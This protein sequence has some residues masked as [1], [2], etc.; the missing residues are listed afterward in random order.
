MYMEFNDFIK[1]VADSI[2]EYLLQYEI[3]KVH[4]DKVSKNNGIVCTGMSIVLKGESI[5]PNIYLDYYYSLYS[6][7]KPF[8]E[9]LVLIRDEYRE[10]RKR[11]EQDNIMTTLSADEVKQNVFIKL[12]NYEKNKDMLENCP[13]IPFLDL[14]VSFRYLVKHDDN[15]IASAIVRNTDME[16]WGFSTEDLYNLAKENTRRLF[17]PSLGRLDFVLKNVVPDADDIPED[18]GLYVLTNEQG[19]NGAVYM[20][21]KDIIA[22]LA[23]EKG[24]SLYILPSSIHEVLLLPVVPEHN[25]EDLAIMVKEIN[26]YVV[27][28]MDYLSDNVY[29]YDINDGTITI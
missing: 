3:D 29:F 16:K 21:Y 18:T 5:S 28:E 17:P 20:I 19:I 2:P 11:L 27:S 14:A 10:A 22:E 7:G 6:R 24:S 9:I 13:Y 23:N 25:K 15:G 1:K 8:E 4:I 26:R 12:I